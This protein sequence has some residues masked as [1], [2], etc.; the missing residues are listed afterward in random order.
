MDFETYYKGQFEADLRALLRSIPEK[1]KRTLWSDPSALTIQLDRLNKGD[2]IE[3]VSADRRPL[4]A[5]CL[6][7]TALIDQAMYKYSG[8]YY[9]SFRR[10]SAYPKLTGAGEWTWC[11]KCTRPIYAIN[12]MHYGDQDGLSKAKAL[13]T[14]AKDYFRKDIPESLGRL[15]SIPDELSE[16]I[17]VECLR[18]LDKTTR[19]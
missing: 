14:A 2:A 13:M 16:R 3:A 7:W 1:H 4:F 6:C 8:H 10:M 12:D 15:F 9:E 11:H 19:A 17:F 5:V 18:E